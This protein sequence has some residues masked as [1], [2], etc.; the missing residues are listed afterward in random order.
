MWGMRQE[1]VERQLAHF[2]TVHSDY[3]AGVRRELDKMTRAKASRSL[4][5][6]KCRKASK[7][8]SNRLTVSRVRRAPSLPSRGG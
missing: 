8:P 2:K 7:P 3:E 4:S 5:S 6:G 1:I